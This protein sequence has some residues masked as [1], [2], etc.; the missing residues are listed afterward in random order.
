MHE[1]CHERCH[2]HDHDHDGNTPHGH[3]HCVE[4]L[5]LRRLDDCR[6]DEQDDVQ[7]QERQEFIAGTGQGVYGRQR[8]EVVEGQAKVHDGNNGDD[9][10]EVNE[11]NA[12]HRE[13]AGLRR[14]VAMDEGGA[15]RL[16]PHV[17]ERGEVRQTELLVLPHN[18]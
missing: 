8:H 18:H 12:A 11:D 3:E 5:C 14:R 10:V 9:A 16:T 15:S 7:P 6:M 13:G 4:G 1:T 2:G 17:V